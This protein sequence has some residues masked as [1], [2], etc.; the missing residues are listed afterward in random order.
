MA[1]IVTGFDFF[2]PNPTCVKAALELRVAEAKTA[3]ERGAAAEKQDITEERAPTK[4]ADTKSMPNCAGTW[5]EIGSP[6]PKTLV[7]TQNG[8]NVNIGGN[9]L[10]IAR[11]GKLTKKKF[12]A[13][14]SKYGHEV[15]TEAEAALVDTFTWRLKGST[16]VSEVVFDY[17]RIY[18]KRP[19]HV[20]R[21]IITYKRI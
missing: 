1:F 8:R 13:S 21:R 3:S 11:D 12:Y 2:L 17:R 15:V 18:G 4:R 5:V 7:I 9:I 10:T 14:D 16:L 20:E 6:K 19:V